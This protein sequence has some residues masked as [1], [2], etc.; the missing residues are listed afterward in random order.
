MET[1]MLKRI[2]EVKAQGVIPVL[3][4]IKPSSPNKGDLLG[5]RTPAEI[6]QAY[7]DGGAA[8]LSVVT[9]RWFGGNINMLKEV[10]EISQLP[11]L[12]KDL[13]VNTEQ[14][15]ES[16]AHGA[17]AV[18]LTT[19]ILQPQHLEKLVH[20]CVKMD[21][22]PFIEVAT[23]DEIEQLPSHDSIVL[24]ITNRDISKK[25]TDTDSGL[26]GMSLIESAVGKAGA[27]ISASGISTNAE[28]N[29]LMRVGFDGLLVGTS[30]LESDNSAQAVRDLSRVR[31]MTE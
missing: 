3:A 20:A 10:A 17:S 6:A 29:L 13:I 15:K 27:I 1:N 19:K 7:I 23:L 5:N 24:G 16:K 18:L 21:M 22:T 30:L 31:E 11:V 12:R 4:E 9:G 14:V 26:K 28:A 2:L 8:C 25:E